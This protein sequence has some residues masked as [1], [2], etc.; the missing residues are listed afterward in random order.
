MNISSNEYGLGGALTNP[1]ELSFLKK[2]VVNH[3]PVKFRGVVYADAEKAYQ[4]TK[5]MSKMMSFEELQDLM[6]EI[7]AAKFIQHPRLIEA[8]AKRGGSEWLKTC[9]HIVGPAHRISRWEGHG[10]QS[11]FI[12]CLTLAYH[13]VTGK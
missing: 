3:Y 4:E 6:V 9:S 7:I 11:A 13:K 10:L 12:K 2:N 1:T 5:R 8:V